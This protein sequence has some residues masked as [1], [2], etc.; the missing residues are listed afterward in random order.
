VSRRSG[1]ARGSTK[2]FVKKGNKRYDRHDAYFRKAKEGG[3]L[4]RSVFKLEEI[5]QSF[6]IFRRGNVVLDLG[7]APGSWLQYA[8]RRIQQEKGHL[9]GIDLLPV[10][11]SFGPHVRIIEGDIYEVTLDELRPE[12]SSSE[13]PPFDVLLSD[14]APNTTGIR[15]VDQARSMSLAE[16]ALELTQDLLKPGGR[17]VVKVFEGGDFHAYVKSMREVFEDV[18]I[19]RPRSTRKTS[20]ETYVVGMRLRGG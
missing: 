11:L 15:S 3:W 16:R 1:G 7:C 2:G 14:M 9:V 10:K 4:A 8:E 13:G 17:F 12:H 18:K 5:D 19:R 6:K 20:M